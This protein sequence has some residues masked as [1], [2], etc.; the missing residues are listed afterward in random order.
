MED[1]VKLNHLLRVV[2]QDHAVL[3]TCLEQLSHKLPS[4]DILKSTKI[5]CQ[6]MLA[7]QPHLLTL[8]QLICY[9]AY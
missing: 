4:R 8:S 2:N 7:Q 9:H 3:L 5:G 6:L 1:I